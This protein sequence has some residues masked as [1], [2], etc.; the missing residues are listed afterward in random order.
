MNLLVGS[1]SSSVALLRFDPAAKTI[2]LVKDNA[3]LAKAPSWIEKSRVAALA[4]RVVYAVSEEAGLALS[5]EVEQTTGDVS[6][7]SSVGT[8]GNPAHSGWSRLP[9]QAY[10]LSR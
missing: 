4:D 5:L 7:S 1:N 8:Y 6:I 2:A 9:A 3:K 10:Y